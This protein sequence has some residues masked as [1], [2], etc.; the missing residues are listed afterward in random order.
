VESQEIY[1]FV[2]KLIDLRRNHPAF[3]RRY[4]VDPFADQ[5]SYEGLSRGSDITWQGTEQ[6][7]PDW[8]YYSHTLALH[9]HGSPPEAAPDSED[10]DFYII[11][12]GWSKPLAFSLPL[13]PPPLHWHRLVD[14]SLTYPEDFLSEDQSMRVS[15]HSYM[16][17]PHSTVILRT[18]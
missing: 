16:A 6:H 13:L 3:R 10:C 17:A 15:G 14:T 9:L 1:S 4:F 18:R 12:N 2:K 11:F 5:R 7:R 8:S